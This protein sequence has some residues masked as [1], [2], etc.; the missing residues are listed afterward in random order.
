[1][2]RGQLVTITR[3]HY[4]DRPGII[5]EISAGKCTIA[6]T[7]TPNYPKHYD[8]TIRNCTPSDYTRR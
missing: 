7:D 4:K 3:G 8:V 2:I 1:M 6:L 5:T